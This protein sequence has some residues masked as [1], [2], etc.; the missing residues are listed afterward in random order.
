MP[1]QVVIIPVMVFP[2]WHAI[3]VYNLF[4]EMEV[5]QNFTLLPFSPSSQPLPLCQPP[6]CSLYLSICF[7]FCFVFILFAFAAILIGEIF[8]ICPS[9]SDLFISLSV[10]YSRSSIIL[11]Q[12]VAKI[13]WTILVYSYVCVFIYVQKCL[14]KTFCGTG[15]VLCWNKWGET[16]SFLYKN[17]Q[18]S[19]VGVVWGSRVCR[20]T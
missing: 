17:K 1:Y 2:M 10:N 9:V 19:W 15:H 16:Q 11:S 5:W 8:S 6:V 13:S 14:L 4:Q 12:E 18:S 3:P 20:H 7:W